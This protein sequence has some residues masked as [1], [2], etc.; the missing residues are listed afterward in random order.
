MT[1][2]HFA[3]YVL[4]RGVAASRPATPTVPDGKLYIYEA[5]DTGVVSL[6]SVGG[7]TWKDVDQ[8]DDSSITYAKIQD[9]SATDKLLGR[10]TAGAGDIEEIVCTSSGRALLDDA[11]AAAQ[12]TTLGLGSGSI[13][14]FKTALTALGSYYDAGTINDDTA[15]EV[16]IGGTNGGLL[17]LVGNTVAAGVALLFIRTNSTVTAEVITQA[18]SGVVTVVAGDGSL[19]GTTGADTKLNIKM[20]SS[21]TPSLWVENRTGAARGYGIYVFVR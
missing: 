10:A 11:S 19:S 3:S 15:V 12:L 9:V 8:I 16:V 18:S 4:E 6:W 7:A 14:G 5:S 1:I 17:F 20:D 2:N 13:S 21:A